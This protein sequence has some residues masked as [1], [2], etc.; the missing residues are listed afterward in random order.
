MAEEQKSRL[1]NVIA[2][3]TA[4]TGLIAAVVALSGLLKPLFGGTSGNVT[5][6][7]AVN[8]AT[9][10]D[11]A[12]PPGTGTASANKVASSG[13]APAGRTGKPGATTANN[14][15]AGYSEAQQHPAAA[16]SE[17]EAATHHVPVAENPAPEESTPDSE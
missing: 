3:M 9:P 12:S 7:A 14:N 13:T 16:S 8:A 1:T 5:T 10:I 6:V 17:G 2:L 11:A 4:V 15:G